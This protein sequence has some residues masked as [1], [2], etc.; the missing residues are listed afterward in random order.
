MNTR[1]IRPLLALVST[2]ALAACGS[3]GGSDTAAVST[4]GFGT[5]TLGIVDA[6]VDGAAKVVIRVTAIEVKRAGQSPV[7]YDISPDRDIDLLQYADGQRAVVLDD[8][9]VPAGRYEWIRLLVQAER[10]QQDGSYVEMLDGRRYPLFVPSGSETGLK[11]VRGFNVAVG[12][13]TDFTIDFD[14][15]R[16]I[17]A[18]PGLDPNLLLKPVLRIVDNL[19]VG[20]IAG[21]VNPLLVVGGCTPFVY[22]FDGANVTPDDLDGVEP[23]PL[24]SVPVRLNESTG[25]YVY[26][27]GFLE[28]ATYTVSFTCDGAN[29]DPE[30][31][32][33]LV[34]QGTQNA[35]V[36]AGQTT[37]IDF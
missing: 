5:L 34:F 23:E 21:T 32:D 4:E 19:Q 10:N 26:K 18:P 1:T 36:T 25:A 24:I 22:V 11:L 2:L 14:L 13:R 12:G 29:D 3:G 30:A 16:S 28:A 7:T 37:V 35:V 6:P 20:R 9:R 33:A 17:I 27:V 8:Q 15:R 31:D